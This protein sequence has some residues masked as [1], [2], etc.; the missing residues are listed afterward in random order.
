MNKVKIT[1]NRK[2]DA[3]MNKMNILMN[4][5][6]PC[7]ICELAAA[8]AL[9]DAVAVPLK[10]VW[11]TRRGIRGTSRLPSAAHSEQVLGPNILKNP[12]II[13]I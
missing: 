11:G 8:A 9:A 4:C 3:S 13:K 7:A 1:I 6:L 10:T 12:M 2:T 5:L